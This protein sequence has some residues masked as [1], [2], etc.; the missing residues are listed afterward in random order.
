[1]MAKPMKTLELH[2]PMIQFFN[3]GAFDIEAFS[4]SRGRLFVLEISG[5]PFCVDFTAQILL[6]N[7]I[8]QWVAVVRIRV[9]LI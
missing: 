8:G 5:W 2:Y 1:M 4:A 9:T 3:K 7:V 6:S